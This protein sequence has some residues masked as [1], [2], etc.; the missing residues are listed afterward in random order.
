MFLF[1]HYHYNFMHLSVQGGAQHRDQRVRGR[2]PLPGSTCVRNGN[3]SRARSDDLV[4]CTRLAAGCG[5]FQPCTSQSRQP[6]PQSERELKRDELR[7][8]CLEG[9]NAAMAACERP[10]RPEAKI[11]AL[12]AT[13]GHQ[14]QQ[15]LAL[16]A[17]AFASSIPLVFICGAAQESQSRLRRLH[18]PG[19]RIQRISESQT[20]S[21]HSQ[22]VSP[23]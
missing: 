14:W 13:R 9:L 7:A 6:K 19:Q 22:S 16:L 17:A 21:R 10:V 20:Y 15:A 8:V 1:A 23:G 11:L 5:A 2:A 3:P 12:S 18:G 4:L